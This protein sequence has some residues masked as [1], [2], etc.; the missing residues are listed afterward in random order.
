VNAAHLEWSYWV[1]GGAVLGSDNRSTRA[2][3][4]LGTELTFHLFEYHGFPAARGS[5]LYSRA[6]VRIGPWASAAE[7]FSIGSVVEGGA[8]M[9]FGGI[10]AP[11]WGTF[12]A[13]AGFGYGAFETE[14]APHFVVTVLWGI[15]GVAARFTRRGYCD[16]PAIP[17]SFAEASV[18][19]LFVTHRRTFDGEGSA[20]TVIGIEVSHSYLLAPYGGTRLWG[21]AAR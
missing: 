8:K 16:P 2:S 6:E 13:R 14:R 7:R 9:H 15:H 11:S 1:G 17:R 3:L 5:N 4:G 18:F 20:E 21:G 12:D 19:R 10:A